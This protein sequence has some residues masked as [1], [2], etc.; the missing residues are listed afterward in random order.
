MT[1]C[2]TAGYIAFADKRQ[3][4]MGAIVQICFFFLFL[5]GIPDRG[6]LEAA[7]EGESRASQTCHVVCLLDDCNAEQ[8]DLN[9]NHCM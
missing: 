9:I 4:R 2:E 7:I 3:M 8:V 5:S 6:M 1:G